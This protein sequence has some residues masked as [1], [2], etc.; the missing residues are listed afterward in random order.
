MT[1]VNCIHRIRRRLSPG[2]F[3]GGPRLAVAEVLIPVTEIEIYYTESGA[4]SYNQVTS[5]SRMWR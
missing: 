2:S 4:P 1:V 5:K 3:Q